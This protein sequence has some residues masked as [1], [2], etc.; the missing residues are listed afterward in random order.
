MQTEKLYSNAT[1]ELIATSV[2]VS[3]QVPGVR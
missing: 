1:Q 3:T 2:S